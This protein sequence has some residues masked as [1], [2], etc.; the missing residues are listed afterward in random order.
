MKSKLGQMRR[1]SILRT[2]SLLFFLNVY[3]ERGIFTDFMLFKSANGEID[4]L[5]YL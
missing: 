5:H 1:N 2:G 4:P 3:Y